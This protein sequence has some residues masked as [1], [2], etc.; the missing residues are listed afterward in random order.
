MQHTIKAYFPKK[1]QAN[2]FKSNIKK[3]RS[4]SVVASR[5]AG[6]MASSQSQS[7]KGFGMIQAFKNDVDDDDDVAENDVNDNNNIRTSL[8]Y[9]SDQ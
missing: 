6:G 4:T 2:K 9:Q 1:Q 5:M 8:N 7:Q 3:I